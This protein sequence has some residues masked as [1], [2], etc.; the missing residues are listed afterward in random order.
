MAI[1][2]NTLSARRFADPHEVP[3]IPGT[4][5]WE[6]MYPYYYT[7]G[8]GETRRE[9]YESSQFWFYDGVHYPVP[10]HPL[11]IIWDDMWHMT[12]SGFT[13][14][15][16]AI[17]N[18]NGIDHRVL[19]GYIYLAGTFPSKEEEEKRVPYVMARTGHYYENFDELYKGWIEKMMAVIEEMKAIH[20]P[21]DLPWVSD[22]SYVFEHKG[23]YE[24]DEILRNW[25]RVLQLSQRAWQLHMEM[26]GLAYGGYVN[27]IYTMRDLF[28]NIA[29]KAIG[30]MLTGFTGEMFRPP[31]ELQKL[32][33]SARQ[34]GVAQAIKD[35]EHWTEMVAKLQGTEAGDRWLAEVE[36]VREPWFEMSIGGGWHH[37]DVAWND[38]LDVPL[39]HIRNYIIM[40]EEGKRIDRPTEEVEAESKRVADEYRSLITND[41]D[42]EI[43]DQRLALAKMVSIFPESHQ[44]YIENWFHA[45]FYRR[46]KELGQMFVSQ[47]VLEDKEDVFF[48]NRFEINPVLYDVLASWSTCVPPIASYEIP[49][50]I[51]RRKEIY[52]KFKEWSPPPALGP[53]PEV[54]TEPNSIVLW[55]VTTEK[56]DMW[57]N[58]AGM[59]AEDV[60]D[61][62]GFAGSSGIVEGTARVCL[63]LEDIAKLKAGDILVGRMT[64]ASWAPAFNVIA[65]C[66]TDIGGTFCHAAIVA[67]EYKM[68]AVVGVGNG[69]EI[70][71][72]GDKL[73]VDGDI[74]VVTILERAN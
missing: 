7:F 60:V 39:A 21:A 23:Y 58:A 57:L 26:D 11:D 14:K 72:S 16:F 28:P 18:S 48:L 33:R 52:A 38:N 40:L 3:P 24:A 10:M 15:V 45:L 61:L 59:K 69:T 49:P 2:S 17:P 64:A 9:E 54:V 27:F 63:E 20:F 34:L 19:N 43:F 4:E 13:S 37:M 25:D 73:R 50:K 62:H 41:Q 30:Q 44:F 74:G 53:A 6:E 46:A 32:A 8:K 1:D 12:L 22:E 71:K 29:D 47:G 36:A 55:G 66:V 65:G 42:R 68:P 56:I 5:G 70:I 31:A 35:S 51:A 67:R